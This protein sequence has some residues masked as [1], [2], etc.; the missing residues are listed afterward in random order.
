MQGYS[1]VTTLIDQPGSKQFIAA[2]V[3]SI[4]DAILYAE[5]QGMRVNWRLLRPDWLWYK[6]QSVLL[7]DWET[8]SPNDNRADMKF[9]RDIAKP[10]SDSLRIFLHEI[11]R[12]LVDGSETSSITSYGSWATA[13]APRPPDI[14]TVNDA[15]SIALSF[16]SVTDLTLPL[17]LPSPLSISAN[18]G[19]VKK[20]VNEMGDMVGRKLTH[21]IL[22]LPKQPRST[23]DAM[24]L[25]CK[26]VISV[27]CGTGNVKLKSNP[28][29]N[30]YL[31]EMG[32][33]ERPA[34]S[35]AEGG[36]LPQEMPSANIEMA[37]LEFVRH[38]PL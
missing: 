7:V 12:S 16:N 28:R 21:R 23:T 26:E 15:A 25:I 18:T 20:Y 10:Q 22:A 32:H 31:V 30:C 37:S 8:C 11:V 24:M 6:K 1:P 4:R 19:E 33:I 13:R 29:T 35:P 2:L 3:P 36:P 34:E 14:Q 27:F 9:L 5:R 38:S 17:A